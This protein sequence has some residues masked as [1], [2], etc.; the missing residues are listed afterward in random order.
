MASG[1]FQETKVRLK[2]GL[3]NEAISFTL[4]SVPGRDL[5]CQTNQVKKEIQ[6]IKNTEVYS[7]LNSNFLD[8]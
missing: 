7:F 6:C 4:L 1:I 3:I 5:S 8:L 2:T